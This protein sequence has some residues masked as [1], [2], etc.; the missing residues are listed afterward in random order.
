LLQFNPKNNPLALLAQTCCSIGKESTETSTAA[1]KTL[2]DNDTTDHGES[3][4]SQLGVS[5]IL[6]HKDD[7][8]DGRKSVNGCVNIRKSNSPRTHGHAKTVDIK[9]NTKKKR[10]DGYRGSSNQTDSSINNSETNSIKHRY[11]SRAI[12]RVP[13][14]KTLP[15]T[16][17]TK[18]VL[19][20]VGKLKSISPPGCTCKSSLRDDSGSDSGSNHGRSSSHSN[21]HSDC[22]SVST[23][24]VPTARSTVAMTTKDAELYCL[25]MLRDSGLLYKPDITASSSMAP[26]LAQSVLK[27]QQHHLQ[28]LHQESLAAAAFHR[29]ATS[30]LIG[31]SSS[32][33]NPSFPGLFYNHPSFRASS[34]DPALA[35]TNSL[36]VAAASGL[37]SYSQQIAAC[38]SGGGSSPYVGYTRVETPSGGSTIVAVCRHPFCFASPSL[39]A[40]HPVSNVLNSSVFPIEAYSQHPT[41]RALPSISLTRANTPA[42]Y[43][44]LFPL[45]SPLY[46]SG[47]LPVTDV[48]KNSQPENSVEHREG[49]YQCS[50]VFEGKF[51]GKRFQ[52]SENLLQHLSTMHT[53][54]VS[55][56]TAASSVLSAFQT[57]H[58][59][60]FSHGYHHPQL[61]STRIAGSTN[62]GDMNSPDVQRR[63]ISPASLLAT[64]SRYHPYKSPF[65]PPYMSSTLTSGTLPSSFMRAYY[66]SPYGLFNHRLGAA[67]VGR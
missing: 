51:C 50:W 13:L 36:K 28:R 26:A 32:A 55:T 5:D 49:S 9:Y 56:D 38:S 45:F 48:H 10:N 2:N 15:G 41:D 61:Y 6:S 63:S 64:K 42:P 29:V 60:P 35:Y 39:N 19:S 23:S 21:A 62:N 24:Q 3:S 14:T 4:P 1:L 12:K 66:S 22:S 25:G 7:V 59:N 20:D 30:E 44:S 67:A 57:I 16:S 31:S 37:A 65:V 53:S 54:C 52:S 58:N 47:S 27:Q 11:K 34:I 43:S 8:I 18:M 33:K 40:P 46:M 17:E